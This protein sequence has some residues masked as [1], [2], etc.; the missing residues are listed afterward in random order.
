MKHSGN[1]D[2]LSSKRT[3][4]QAFNRA[5]RGED[6]P[7]RPASQMGDPIARKIKWTVTGA[8][9]VKATCNRTSQADASSA[10]L[11]PS[12]ASRSRRAARWKN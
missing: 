2:H 6:G 4:M 5:V 9:P 10:N 11:E 8:A 3:L 7:G 12:T 1:A